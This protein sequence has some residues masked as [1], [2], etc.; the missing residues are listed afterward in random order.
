MIIRLYTM[1]G[2][3]M[4]TPVGNVNLERHEVNMRR[5]PVIGTNGQQVEIVEVGEHDQIM[6]REGLWMEVTDI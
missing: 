1:D 6:S 4:I 2:N 3:S 5:I